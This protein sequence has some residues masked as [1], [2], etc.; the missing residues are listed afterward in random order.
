VFSKIAKRISPRFQR[1]HRV[2]RFLALSND[3]N[4]IETNYLA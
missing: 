3:A 1:K 4:T 2:L